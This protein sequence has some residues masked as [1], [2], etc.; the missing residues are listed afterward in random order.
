MR[1]QIRIDPIR[2]AQDKLTGGGNSV[3][4]ERLGLNKI[5]RAKEDPAK[6]WNAVYIIFSFRVS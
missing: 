4:L 1:I 3:E 5:G 2:Q 6:L